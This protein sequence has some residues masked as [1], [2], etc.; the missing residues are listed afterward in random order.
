MPSP[1]RLRSVP[2]RALLDQGVTL[3]GS[4]DA[5]IAAF[6]PLAGM[7]AAV[8]RT[9]HAGQVHQAD[10]A[11]M[12]LEALRL[13]TAGAALAANR[14][15]DLGCIRPG[16]RAGLVVLSADPLRVAPADL[17]RVRVEHTLVAGQTLFRDER[18]VQEETAED[19]HD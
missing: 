12:P 16:A 6:E 4:S 11:I 3:A 8:T 9:T 1:P 15:H 18:G 14:A 5:P 19:A 17:G 7:Q 13:W 2:L 10:Q